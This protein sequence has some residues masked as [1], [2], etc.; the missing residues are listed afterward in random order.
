M[1]RADWIAV[2]CASSVGGACVIAMITSPPRV[3]AAAIGESASVAAPIDSASARFF[4]FIR[5]PRLG[6]NSRRRLFAMRR[7]GECK[8]VI[9]RCGHC[10]AQSGAPRSKPYADVL[11]LHVAEQRFLAFFAAVARALG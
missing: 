3:C 7:H 1:W 2:I 4:Q 11:R 9:G 5:V 6:G 8:D 10:M